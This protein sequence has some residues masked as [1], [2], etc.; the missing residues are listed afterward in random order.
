MV[1]VAKVKASR[2]AWGRKS[3][4]TVLPPLSMVNKGI[5]VHHITGAVTPCLQDKTRGV[6]QKVDFKVG[7][8]AVIQ[9]NG[10]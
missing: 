2:A 8:I 3:E 9:A 7:T 10:K 1:E 5:E 4:A 6:G